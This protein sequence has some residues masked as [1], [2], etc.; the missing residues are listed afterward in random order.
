MA[1]LK[2]LIVNGVARVIG[3]LTAS[4]IIKQGGVSSQ[5][6]KADG[7]VDSTSYYH[8][9]NKPSLSDLG[10]AAAGHTHSYLPLSGGTI[11]GSLT[12]A[13][14]TWNV[15]GD[16]AAIGDYNVAGSLGLKSVNNNIPSIGFHN[17]SNTLLGTLKCDAGT[18][19]WNTNTIWH[20]GNDGNGSSLDADLLDGYHAN[21]FS[22]V[23]HDHQ[24]IA[25][26]SFQGQI[27]GT[28]AT[29]KTDIHNVLS[30]I[31]GIGKH[32]VVS[33]SIIGNWSNDSASQ[34]PSSVSSIISINGGYNGTYYGQFLVAS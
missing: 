33:D 17:S 32:I 9:G 12:F 27:G 10:A 4:K 19:K 34:S 7:S 29:Y 20:A 21:S 30:S 28:V 23:G 2:S 18:L 11:T 1:I 26:T 14:G 24:H 16:D 8:S 13:N 5:F 3:D 22:L 6:L 25:T 15:V 31:S